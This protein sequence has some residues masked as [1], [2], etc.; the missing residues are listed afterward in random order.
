[1]E[2][3]LTD[4]PLN[5]DQAR[6]QPGK[7]NTHQ[8]FIA[9]QV[10]TSD[11][12]FGNFWIKNFDFGQADFIFDLMGDGINNGVALMSELQLA[13]NKEMTDI[14][15]LELNLEIRKYN[16][17]ITKELF[18]KN[19]L[20]FFSQL[21]GVKQLFNYQFAD[22]VL[23][24]SPTEATQT[25]QINQI[26]IQKIL[27]KLENS[28]DICTSPCQDRIDKLQYFKSQLKKAGLTIDAKKKIFSRI[29]DLTQKQ[30]SL[31]LG[32]Q[33]QRLNQIINLVGEENIW[34]RTRISNIHR[35][36]IPISRNKYDSIYSQPIGKYQGDSRLKEIKK[37]YYFAPMMDYETVQFYEDSQMAAGS[38]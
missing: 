14:D 37:K 17:F 19:Y 32:A 16:K 5:S 20:N 9:R 29:V 26:A 31:F 7:K 2:F 21:S 25:W 15:Q 18:I 3:N 24:V 12:S 13:A 22:G 11:R 35:T 4:S 27:T 30:I 33:F 1:M 8:L 38:K 34:L 10:N 28:E 36:D 23:F 6:F